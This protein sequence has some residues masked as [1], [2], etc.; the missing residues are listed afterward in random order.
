MNTRH[1]KILI[2]GGSGLVGKKLTH[3]LLQKGYE[4]AILSRNNTRSA[5]ATYYQWDI[6]K[7]YINPEALQNTQG[8]IHLAGAGV[9]DKN[10]TKERKQEI[11]ESRIRSTELLYNSL[12]ELDE[13]PLSFISASAIGIYGDRDVNTKLTESSSPGNGFLAEVTQLWEK[14]IDKVNDLGIRTAKIRIG[15][16]LSTQGGAL[17]KICQPIKLGAGAP[18]GSGEQG[19]SWIHI[20]DLCDIFIYALENTSIQGAY[21]AVAPEPVDNSLLTKAIAKH[22]KKLLLLP[23]VPSFAL[24]LMLGEMA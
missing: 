23:N 21:N 12:K 17:P 5:E 6:E 13:K 2:T 9:A 8:I 7:G 1:K 11:L 3:K 4:V 10:W 16:V 20:D 24:K 18:L 22:L 15:I 14:S 19:V